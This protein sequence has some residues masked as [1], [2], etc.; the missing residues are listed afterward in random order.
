MN[1]IFFFVKINELNNKKIKFAI[2]IL[3]N[4]GKKRNEKINRI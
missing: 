2:I 1:N 4:I 3:N